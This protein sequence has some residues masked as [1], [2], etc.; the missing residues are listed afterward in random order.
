MKSTSS[1]G[2]SRFTHSIIFHANFDKHSVSFDV[3]STIDVLVRS[4]FPRAKAGVF[5]GLG[6]AKKR[7]VFRTDVRFDCKRDVLSFG[8]VC[9]LIQ[10]IKRGAISE[11]PG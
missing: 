6:S 11:R 8:K 4:K 9:V 2:R 5:A 7:L 1:G 10:K 3:L